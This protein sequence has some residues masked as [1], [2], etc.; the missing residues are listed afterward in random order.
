M[1]NLQ[2][3]QGVTFNVIPSIPV[4][5]AIGTGQALIPATRYPERSGQ[6]L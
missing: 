5:I 6:A 4:P 1:D 3:G 2:L